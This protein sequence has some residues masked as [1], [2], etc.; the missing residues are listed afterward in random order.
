M[1]RRRVRVQVCIYDSYATAR[2]GEVCRGEAFFF[3][4][5]PVP[6][7]CLLAVAVVGLVVALQYQR[8]KRRRLAKMVW[9]AQQ[10]NLESSSSFGTIEFI[11][12]ARI[13]GSK[14]SA[15]FEV[16]AI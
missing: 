16:A 3:I 4:D 1:A 14:K 6:F 7:L 2:R 15:G 10:K 11:E 8:R 12:E 13:P 5:S 9:D